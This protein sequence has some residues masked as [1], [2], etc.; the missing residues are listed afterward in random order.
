VS[1]TFPTTKKSENGYAID[2]VEEFLQAA[3]TAFDADRALTASLTSRDIRRT[4]FPLTKGGY[5]IRHVDAALERLED[6]FATREKEVA[7]AAGKGDDW[8][9]EARG[10]AQAVLDRLARGK[11]KRF[12]R[13]GFLRE[14][15]SI[16][17][18][19][20]F[21]ERLIAYFQSGTHLTVAD[22]RAVTF[23]VKTRGYSERQVD[24]LLDAVI[25]A[26]LAVR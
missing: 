12:T 3:R 20:A 26:M 7:I 14:G 24:E 13:A 2:R 5:S 17:D 9:V 21:S 1:S 6:A 22:V 19:D 16:R 23:R 11:G 8:I 15:Y 4:S 25:E 10:T 18:V